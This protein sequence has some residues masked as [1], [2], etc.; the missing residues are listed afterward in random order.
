MGQQTIKMCPEN[1]LQF[2]Y[3][4][5]SNLNG[6]FSWFVNGQQKPETTAVLQIDWSGFALGEYVIEVY[7]ISQFG[8]GSDILS[9]TVTLE[10]CDNSQLYAPN[11]FTPDGDRHNNTWQPI[12]TNCKRMNTLIY[13][14]WGELIFQSSD[15]NPEWDGTFKGYMSP[16]GVY[17]YQ[18]RW[19]DINNNKFNNVGH[20]V[21]IR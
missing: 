20:I 12:C 6:T 10:E 4:T 21:L 7:Q 18:I 5:N 8:C 2:E 9:F 16:D 3:S 13:S 11:A 14:R 17:V 1:S 15:I 19:V